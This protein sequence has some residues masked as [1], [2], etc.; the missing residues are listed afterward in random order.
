LANEQ[1]S[2]NNLNLLPRFRGRANE[3]ALSK[4]N[5]FLT[6]EESVALKHCLEETINSLLPET[7]SIHVY[8]SML[9]A[10]YTQDRRI[11]YINSNIFF[12]GQYGKVLLMFDIAFNTYQIKKP[13]VFVSCY[14]EVA[15][16]L[17]P[18]LGK[19]VCL[20]KTNPTTYTLVPITNVSSTTLLVPHVYDRTK[21][22][23]YKKISSSSCICT[24]NS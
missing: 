2:N 10:N 14:Q 19:S 5:N 23:V 11:V 18:A 16:N 20:T 6:T 3:V 12:C 15:S 13:L 24:P 7:Q 4:L 1:T 8:I 17:S 21:F 22:W 9:P